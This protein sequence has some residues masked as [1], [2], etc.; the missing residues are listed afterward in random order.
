[1][2]SPESKSP[3][4]Q[5]IGV[6]AVGDWVHR[7]R[8][9]PTILKGT[10]DEED[11]YDGPWKVLEIQRRH[12]V[13]HT[14]MV[15]KTPRTGT[16]S[17]IASAKLA[18]PEDSLLQKATEG[19][20]PLDQLVKVKPTL[21]KS[22][23]EMSNSGAV[24]HDHNGEKYYSVEKIRGERSGNLK[25]ANIPAANSPKVSRTGVKSYLVHWAGYPS[26]DDSWEIGHKHQCGGVPAEF[27]NEWK[28]REN[29]WKAA[30]KGVKAKT[31]QKDVKSE[32]IRRY[33]R[34]NIDE[35]DD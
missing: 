27:I 2:P 26:E 16:E 34:D 20:V 29:E 23:E 32:L 31:Q 7:L 4:T 14:P 30:Q 6:V 9:A 1:M 24:Y 22:L 17:L 28:Q 8:P 35:F 10:S 25:S 5:G 21:N 18:I 33:Y 12:K 15:R 13:Q 19:W 11:L 3:S